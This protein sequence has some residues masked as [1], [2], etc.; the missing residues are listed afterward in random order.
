MDGW[1]RPAAACASRRNR[2]KNDGSRARS[3]RKILIA[4]GRE[5]L[6]SRP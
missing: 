6:V 5:S 3:L 4:T 2:V 1:L